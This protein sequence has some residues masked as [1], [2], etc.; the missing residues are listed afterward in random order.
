MEPRGSA[1]ARRRL[2]EIQSQLLSARHAARL[3]Q[4]MI[5]DVLGVSS[6]TLRDWER[7]HDTPS[8]KHLISW[9]Y[10][11]GF[12]LTI[13]DPSRPSKTSPVAL[14]DGES[15]ELHELRRLAAPLASKRR[16]RE[17]SPGDLA[18]LLGVSRSS[19]RRWEDGQKFPRPVALIAWANRLKCSVRLER[20]AP[21]YI[22]SANPDQDSD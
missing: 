19:V 1:G 17:L 5:S 4:E 13:V 3:T 20:V 18:L 15:L 9:A 16:A 14:E 21:S 22:D 6:R 2:S 12:R 8:L 10:A 7:D 11:L